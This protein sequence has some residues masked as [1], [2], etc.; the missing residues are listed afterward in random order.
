MRGEEKHDVGP[1]LG[2]ELR[3]RSLDV[4]RDRLRYA[5]KREDMPSALRA[6]CFT[7][8]DWDT[9]APR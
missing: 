5:G 6:V 3:E 7:Q 1:V 8:H 2:R 9:N 4:L